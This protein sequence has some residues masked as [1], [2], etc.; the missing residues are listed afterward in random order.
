MGPVKRP[1]SM[2]I[3]KTLTEHLE[4]YSN[5]EPIFK[6]HGHSNGASLLNRILIES[7]NPKIITGITSG[8]QLCA[9]MWHDDSFHVG[10]DDNAYNTPKQNLTKR[11]ILQLCGE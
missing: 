11:R 3:S 8:S 2:L 5:V 10:G 7:D 1:D 9:D 6:F 4:S